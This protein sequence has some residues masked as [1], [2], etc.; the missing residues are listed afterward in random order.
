M[1]KTISTGTLSLRFMQNAQR[2]K[3][4][5]EVELERAEVQDDGKW[6][7]SQAIKD[8]WG[9]K[10][11]E[12]SSSSQTID[13]HEASYLPFIFTASGKGD[14]DTS[15]DA[16]EVARQRLPGRRVFNKR[17]EEVPLNSSEADAESLPKTV[18]PESSPQ[19]GGR[20]IHPRPVTISATASGSRGALLKGFD[21]F[22]QTRIFAPKTDYYK[23][24]AR[25]EDTKAKSARQAVFETTDVGVDLR[26]GQTKPKPPPLEAPSSSATFMKPPGVDVPKEMISGLTK[27]R[28][29]TKPKSRAQEIIEGARA[30]QNNKQEGVTTSEFLKP[31]GVDDAPSLSIDI[32]L[33]DTIQQASNE[34]KKKKRS[35]RERDDLQVDKTPSRKK[36]KT[37]DA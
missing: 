5:K 1:S 18:I 17:G 25:S 22:E 28:I 26:V 4:L 8:A 34:T 29:S 3:Q 30:K 36:K 12:P 14:A 13:V 31:K 33:N 15:A 24:N 16:N 2:A 27:G 19:P 32:S 21:T 11:G 6:E 20:K 37:E 9:L 23:G 35:K 10:E 7:V